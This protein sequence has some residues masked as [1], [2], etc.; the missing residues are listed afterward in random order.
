M[1]P[2]AWFSHHAAVHVSVSSL[3][4]GVPFSLGGNSDFCLAEILLI[5]CHTLPLE[6]CTVLSCSSSFDVNALLLFVEGVRIT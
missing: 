1:S 2:I 3:A 5:L 4:D 6:N